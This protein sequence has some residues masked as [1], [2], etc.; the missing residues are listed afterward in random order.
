MTPP[1]PGALGAI[2][3]AATLSAR[4]HAWTR[5]AAA[6]TGI[7][8]A[9]AP[10]SLAAVGLGPITQQSALGASLRVVVPATLADGEDVP[11]ECFKLAPA[12]RDADGIP[13]ILFGRVSVERTP[14]GTQLVVTSA[15]PVNDPVVR[16]TIQAGC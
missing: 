16:V 12:Q 3:S 1:S 2:A 9:L 10:L 4:A 5:L 8:G 13:Q 11:P 7:L 6:V 14:S 15:R